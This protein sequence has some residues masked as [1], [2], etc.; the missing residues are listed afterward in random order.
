M[1][2][3]WVR[4]SILFVIAS[5]AFL[6]PPPALA[7]DCGVTPC[8]CGD[9]V[10]ADRTLECGIDPITAPP[11]C[12]GDGLIVNPG[13]SLNLGGCTIRG[14]DGGVG[15]QLGQGALVE[16]GK[17]VGF[18]TGVSAASDAIV[19]VVR[20][21]ET[22]TAGIDAA[23]D[24]IR[25]DRNVLQRNEGIGISAVGNTI[26]VV[27]N[28]I[29]GLNDVTTGC[30]LIVEGSDNVVDRNIVLRGGA[31]GIHI[32]GADGN[33]VRNQAKYTQAGPG[34]VFDG[35]TGQ[36]V[37]LN[38]SLGA[39]DDSSFHGFHVL[40]TSTGNTFARNISSSNDGFG[41]KDESVGTGTS[42][43]GNT[44]TRNNC[45]GNALGNSMPDGLC[46]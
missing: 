32:S 11:P 5:I 35:A 37:T 14:A 36:E 4:P 38:T 40:S 33:V 39:E 25:I 13:V 46:Q 1:N 34:F 23:G 22:S 21:S 15:V 3:F 41:I 27:Q 9:T 6:S 42:G 8:S 17:I 44:Y 16:A 20:I 28:R 30:G 18:A 26:T 31:C 43:T 45:T 29:E 24:G 2:R 10:T 7:A 19:R 12:G